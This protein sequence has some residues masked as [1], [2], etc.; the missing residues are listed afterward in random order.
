MYV[1]YHLFR[2]HH[3]NPN[4]YMDMGYG[5]RCVMAA[6]VFKEIEDKRKEYEEVIKSVKQGG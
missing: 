3:W 6:F 1:I 4:D 5:A 2:Y